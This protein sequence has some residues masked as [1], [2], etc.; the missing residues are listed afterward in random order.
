MKPFNELTAQEAAAA[1]AAGRLTSERLVAACLERIERRE[2]D[3]RAWVHLE[4]EL[5]LEQARSCD[6]GPVRGPLHGVPVGVKDII[7]TADQPT[8]CGSPIYEGHRPRADAAC[9]ALVR[10]AG[11]VILGKTVTTEFAFSTPNKTRNPHDPAHT[12]GGSSSGSAAAVADAMIPLA[13]GTQTGGSVIRPASFCGVVGYKA[14]FDGLQASG[15]KVLS[16]A[17]D[18]LGVF[19]RSVADICLM[20]AVQMGAPATPAARGGAPRFGLCR[21]PQWDSASAESRTAI[22]VVGKSLGAEPVDLPAEFAGLIDAQRAVMVFEAAR[23]L[24]WERADRAELLSPKLRATLDEGM[25]IPFAHYREAREL[26]SSCRPRLAE[27]FGRFDALVAPSAV[28]EAPP[29]LETT[30][31]PL[32]NSMWTLLGN[33]C[34]T[35]PGRTGPK[36]LP[37]GVQLV[38]P[39]GADDAL[40]SVAAWAEPRIA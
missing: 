5:A 27:V 2:P 3:V 8:A 21:T 1:I 10:R 36:G 19:A 9:V 39:L 6:R 35:L 7:D 24:A 20:R 28:G 22:E 33:P 11:G 14:S 17:L 26:A 32:F 4:P 12:P 30:G 37:V 25:A 18:T 13:F 31:D 15:V 16:Q 40:L 29:S 23:N 34:V 38:G